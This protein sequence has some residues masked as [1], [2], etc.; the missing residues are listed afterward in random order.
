MF[1]TF[2]F[3]ST[4]LT[5]FLFADTIMLNILNKDTNKTQQIVKTPNFIIYEI[6]N[7]DELIV[8]TSKCKYKGIAYQEFTSC[9]NT[10]QENDF[11][12]VKYYIYIRP[13]LENK[14]DIK[15]K[16]TIIINGY[17][18]QDN[19]NKYLEENKTLTFETKK[20]QFDIKPTK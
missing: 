5:T 18:L 19:T 15:Y 13:Y 6:E 17:N 3:S 9:V 11:H 16:D 2:I 4:I 20:F 12:K 10:I 14:D 7:N 1:K 8:E